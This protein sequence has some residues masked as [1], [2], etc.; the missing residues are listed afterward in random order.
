MF[1]FLYFLTSASE[2][3]VRVTLL[4]SRWCCKLITILM[5]AH[6]DANTFLFS[7]GLESMQRVLTH[8]VTFDGSSLVQFKYFCCSAIFKPWMELHE[9]D[10]CEGL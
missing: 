6:L 2:R 8:A 9:L 7:L 3:K 1:Y 5:P 10:L 4:V